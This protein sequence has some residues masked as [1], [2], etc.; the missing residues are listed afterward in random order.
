MFG[1]VGHSRD[2]RPDDDEDVFDVRSP[3]R[4]DDVFEDGAIAQRQREL[5]PAHAT[6]LAGGGQHGEPHDRRRLHLDAAAR[7]RS[8]V[9]RLRRAINSATMLT[10]ISGTVCEPMARP[11]GACTRASASVRPLG[12]QILEDQLDLA[13][14]A[15]H[16]D[17]ARPRLGEMIQRSSSWLWPR[18]TIRQYGRG[19][20]LAASCCRSGR[21]RRRA[22]AA[23]WEALAAGISA[24]GRR[25][26]TRRNRPRPPVEPPP[27][28][29]GRR[30]RS[31]A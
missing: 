22:D 2:V 9:P 13:F 8:L 16:A 30:R 4:G 27:D 11:S 5:G 10:A 29:H 24:H 26:P 12:E 19:C 23:P 28:R 21:S 1:S 18:V 20:H 15:D 7:T 14:A 25:S 3:E 31:A 6:A 17:V